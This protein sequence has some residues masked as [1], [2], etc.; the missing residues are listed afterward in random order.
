MEAGQEWERE[1]FVWSDV[2]R[3]VNTSY[4]MVQIRGS[5][6]PGWSILSGPS[7]TG[8]PIGWQGHIHDDDQMGGGST[9]P[10]RRLCRRLV[11]ILLRPTLL[12][13][14]IPFPNILW[15]VWYWICVL[16]WSITRGQRSQSGG[17][18]RR[19]WTGG[20]HRRQRGSMRRRGK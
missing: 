3:E 7:T 16:R 8:W 15:L 5:W 13:I 12:T 14:R 6:R 20:F 2:C 10:W 19:A 4:Y 9:H 11:C 17:G 1:I 18:S